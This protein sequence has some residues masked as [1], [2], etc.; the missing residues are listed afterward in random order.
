MTNVSETASGFARNYIDLATNIVSAYVSNNSVRVAD[1]PEVIKSVHAAFVSMASG[2]AEAEPAE[3]DMEK[4]ST[5]QIRRSIAKNGIVSFIDG[6]SYKTL[7][8][9]LT[10]HGLNPHSYR[11]RYDLPSDYPMTCPSYSEMRSSLAKSI[12][13]GLVGARATQAAEP[14]K[15]RSKAA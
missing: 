4:P 3:V 9:H 2:G 6:K 15:D 11:E 7:K 12:G 1:L 13:L 8:R 10:K 5:A 14:S